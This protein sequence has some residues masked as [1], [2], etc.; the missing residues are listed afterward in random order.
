MNQL[1]TVPFHG[2]QLLATM[3]NGKPHVAVRPITEKLGLNWVGQFERIKRHPVLG[4]SSGVTRTVAEDGKTREMVTLP[5]AMLNGWLFGIATSRVKPQYREALVQYQRECFDVLASHFG[6]SEPA[7]A[8]AAASTAA[9]DRE[10]ITIARRYEGM[11]EAQDAKI[12]LLRELTVPQLLRNNPE[13]KQAV[14]LYKAQGITNQQ[15][16]QL[17]GIGYEAWRKLLVRLDALGIIEYTPN[18]AQSAAAKAARQRAIA[19]G[20]GAPSHGAEHMK[21]MR[22]AS[23]AKRLARK[24]AA[25][26]AKPD[27]DKL[28]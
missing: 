25:A 12:N 27:D 7:H 9:V 22:D 26:A 8:A 5:I 17:Y 13:W 6:A 2:N 16:A 21:R 3:V 19:A 4:P 23:T 1:I 15:K 14:K 20:K 18:P 24:A 10:W 28:H 11:M